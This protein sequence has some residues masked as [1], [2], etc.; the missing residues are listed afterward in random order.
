MNKKRMPQCDWCG[1]NTERNEKHDAHYCK[2]CDK[3]L[4]EVCGDSTCEF[5]VGRPKKPSEV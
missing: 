2:T 4:E 1:G 5:C 3:W